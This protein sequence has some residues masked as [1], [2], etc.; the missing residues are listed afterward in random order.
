VTDYFLLLSESR[1]PW[2]APEALKQKFLNL[3]AEVHPDRVHQASP[4]EQRAAQARYTELNAAYQCL[5]EPKQRLR[6]LLELERGA[7]LDELQQ[8]PQDLMDVFFSVSQLCRQAD[9]FLTEKSKAAS[10]MLKAQIFERGLEWTDKLMSMQK[11]INARL[12]Q[13]TAEIK[14]IDTEWLNNKAQAR[15]SLLNQL[16]KLARLLG[17]YERWGSQL[18]ERIV[19]LSF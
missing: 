15:D 1:R 13:L 18:Q 19:R 17:F 11:E 2:L 4:E 9:A 16:E 5:R 12:E 8:V 7:K 6:H 14:T 3:S 10:P